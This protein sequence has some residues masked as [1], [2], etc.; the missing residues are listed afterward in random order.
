MMGFVQALGE[1]S[2]EGLQG[3]YAGRRTRTLGPYAS[4]LLAV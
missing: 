1:G 2:A 3:I 4:T